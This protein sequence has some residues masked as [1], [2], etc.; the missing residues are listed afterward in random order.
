M[1]ATNFMRILDYSMRS[2]SKGFSKSV[3]NQPRHNHSLRSWLRKRFWYFQQL[4]EPRATEAAL[5]T[6]RDD[7]VLNTG[8]VRAVIE[9]GIKRP[10][11][12]LLEAYCYRA[13]VILIYSG[14]DTMAFLNMPANRSDVMR[15]DFIEWAE[16]YVKIAGPTPP[17]G[18][19]LYGTRCSVLHGGAPSRFTRE[20][21][22]RLIRHSS[23]DVPEL[24]RAFFAGVDQF[25]VDLAKDPEKAE[26]ANRR[27]EELEA[28]GPQANR[29]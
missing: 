21:R 29:S 26:T 19:D 20:G 16:R 18:T 14:M 11:R 27:L 13:A 5:S 1:I 28:N 7:V 12:L 24:V 17:T 6:Q 4:S 3:L 9:D 8:A 25:L 10:I 2:Q 23:A 15:S 22:G